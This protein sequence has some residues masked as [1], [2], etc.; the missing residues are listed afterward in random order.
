[1]SRIVRHEDGSTTERCDNG[2]TITRDRE[3]E[4]IEKTSTSNISYRISGNCRVTVTK[5]GDG[6]VINWQ[7]HK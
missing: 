3:G 2:N 4:V 5:D 1:M 7:E 6:R